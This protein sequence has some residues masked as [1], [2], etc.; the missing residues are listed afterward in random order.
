MASTKIAKLW[1][2]H[3]SMTGDPSR[4]M[5]YLIDGHQL[6]PDGRPQIWT[7]S[8]P[9]NCKTDNATLVAHWR[10]IHDQFLSE[11]A[12]PGSMIHHNA[13][14]TVRQFVINLP[15]CISD[16]Q[17]NKLAKAVLQDFPR[18]IPVSMVLH[19]TSNRGK[20]HT[21]LQ[22]LFSYRNGGYGAIND[23]FRLNITGLM[24]WTVRR[25]LTNLGYEVDQ[26]SP[27][28]GINT[29]ERR[30]LNAQ[31]TVEQRRNP[32]IMTALS[33]KA[34][35]PR[36]KAY[37]AKQAE[38]MTA[39]VSSLSVSVDDTLKIMTTMETIT[40]LLVTYTQHDNSQ[41]GQSGGDQPQ[42]ANQP[43]TQQQLE[44]ALMECEKMAAYEEKFKEYQVLK[45]RSRNTNVPITVLIKFKERPFRAHLISLYSNGSP[46]SELAE[47]VAIFYGVVG[48]SPQTLRKILQRCDKEAWAAA[49][50]SYQNHRQVKPSCKNAP[51]P[52]QE[53]EMRHH[54]TFDGLS[55]LDAGKSV[56][57]IQISHGDIG[58]PPVLDG[59]VTDYL[60]RWHPRLRSLALDFIMRQHALLFPYEDGDEARARLETLM[61]DRC[62]VPVHDETAPDGLWRHGDALRL[63]LALKAPAFKIINHDPKSLIEFAVTEMI[64][65]AYRRLHALE[66]PLTEWFFSVFLQTSQ[67]TQIPFDVLYTHA[68]EQTRP[69]PAEASKIMRENA[70]FWK[71]ELQSLGNQYLMATVPDP[72][73]MTLQ[74]A[75]LYQQLKRFLGEET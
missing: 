15:N 42:A 31:G 53:N 19:K 5:A 60:V 56:P 68:I 67:P 33:E 32:R 41:R 73:L 58:T 4:H 16:E 62:A 39:R 59:S 14:I 37:C 13:K 45:Q 74:N 1:V 43:L 38:V 2:N 28:C 71:A 49:T 72:R 22:G 25:E 44:L 34:E 75:A 9:K 55:I 18:H 70:I 66:K 50:E 64:R 27:G 54:I 65:N 48:L 26:G 63:E 3:V 23:E 8:L 7:K 35:S 40:D 57:P 17:V 21:H 61:S 10:G 11:R 36:L 69:T 47:Y 24:K 30:W 29:K 6:A 12:T 51:S 52:L 20:Q 46:L